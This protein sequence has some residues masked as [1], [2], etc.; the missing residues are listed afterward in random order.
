MAPRTFHAGNLTVHVFE[1]R[2]EMGAAAAAASEA[3]ILEVLSRKD[4]ATLLFAAAPSQNEM[5][6]GLRASRVI[7][8]TRIEAFHLDEYAGISA[9]HP[10]S[11]RRF[12]RE[13]L[14][15]HVPVRAFHELRGDAADLD[16]ECARYAALL[17]GR[18]IDVAMLG[19]GENGHLAFIDPPECDFED[20]RVVRV[21][22]LEEACRMQQVHEGAFARLE[23]VPAR[24]LSMT[25]PAL[26]RAR[27]AVVTVP[28]AS[29]QR[30]VRAALEDPISKACPASILRRRAGATL[31]LDR[32][33][34]ALL[35][36]HPAGGVE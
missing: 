28:A 25:V 9:A 24:A 20:R 21:V 19:I 33:S 22:N 5:L 2:T 12:L 26:M 14:L 23:D 30:A 17:A 11:F 4:A 10:V 8:W 1:T 16:A 15:S 13:R 6:A 27:R 34:A 36:P 18:E 3:A 29:K 32:E 35:K 7:D 31:F